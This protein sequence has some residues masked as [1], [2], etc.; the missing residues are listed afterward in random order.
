MNVVALAVVATKLPVNVVAFALVA[1]K[2]PVKV[3]ALTPEN[4]GDE[5][6]LI[7]CGKLNVILPVDPLAVI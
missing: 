1:T 6:V 5:A 3:A 2:L 4:V 7:L